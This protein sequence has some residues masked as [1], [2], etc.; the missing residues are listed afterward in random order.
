MK[1]VVHYIYNKCLNRHMF[2]QCV[3][4]NSDVFKLLKIMFNP[5]NTLEQQSII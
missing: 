5:P 3:T 1:T 4:R 2:Y